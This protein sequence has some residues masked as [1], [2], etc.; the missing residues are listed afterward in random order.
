MV[1]HFFK[2]IWNKKGQHFLLILEIMVAYLVVFGIFSAGVFYYRN[3][4]HPR[5]FEHKNVWSINFSNHQ[6][7]TSRADSLMLILKGVKSQLTAMPGVRG[8]AYMGY[9][10]PYSNSMNGTGFE[11][12]GKKYTSM[13]YQTDDDLRQVLQLE[14][15]KGRWYS[16]QDAAGK[17]RAVVINE[18]LEEQI[19]PLGDALGKELKWSGEQDSRVIVGV[20]K[21]I[22]HEGD[23]STPKPGIYQRADTGFYGWTGMMLVRVDPSVDAGFES[24]VHDRLTS[25]M[26]GATIEIG[27][28]PD[29]LARKNREMAIP[30]VTAGVVAAFLVINVALG[31]FGVLWYNINRRRQE[32]GLRRA[33]GATAGD[34]SKQILGETLVL[35]T[36]AVLLALFFAVQFPLL[37]VFGMLPGIYVTGMLLAVLFIYVLVFLCA[38]Y[39][40][41]EAAAIY[42]AVALHED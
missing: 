31:L 19:F 24:R 37:H 33:I 35:T 39:P 6:A 30:L 28:L 27:R 36:I 7:G 32:I 20:V 25:L 23:Y 14:M 17:R 10:T 2:L 34:V 22:K 11:Y 8:V 21:D 16:E 4:A 42:P 41:R 38:L 1:S 9:N 5:N 12:D 13:D 18:S 29:Q 3:Y 15:V 26:K 40:G